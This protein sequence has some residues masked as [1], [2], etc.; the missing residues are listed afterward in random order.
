MKRDL[1]VGSP[2]H[3]ANAVTNML[4][5]AYIGATEYATPSKNRQPALGLEIKKLVSFTSTATKLAMAEL[6]LFNVSI[7]RVS[8]TLAERSYI[9][10]YK[11]C[12]EC[13]V[14]VNKL[15]SIISKPAGRLGNLLRSIRYTTIYFLPI[16]VPI[17]SDVSMSSSVS[18][19]A[20]P[21]SNTSFHHASRK[22]TS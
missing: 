14:A 19:C 17:R 12:C 20:F 16:F 18:S 13:P 2:Q 9:P 8:G 15:Q 11:S 7:A 1:D 4:A 5:T 22:S 10:N 21:C 3:L 6:L